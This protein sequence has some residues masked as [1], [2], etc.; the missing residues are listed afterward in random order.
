MLNNLMVPSVFVG[1]IKQIVDLF[2]NLICV[3]MEKEARASVDHH[4]LFACQLAP[5]PPSL[6]LIQTQ[7]D[8]TSLAV[9]KEANRWSQIPIYDFSSEEAELKWSLINNWGNWP[10]HSTSTSSKPISNIYASDSF[11]EKPENWPIEL[12][13]AEE[14][15][16]VNRS[17]LTTITAHYISSESNGNQSILTKIPKEMKFWRSTALFPLFSSETTPTD[18]SATTAK[19]L[20]V[21]PSKSRRV[22]AT[23]KR[24]NSLESVQVFATQSPTEESMTTDTA[25]YMEIRNTDEI[26]FGNVINHPVQIGENI[27]LVI[28]RKSRNS[29]DDGY[30]LFVHSCYASDKQGSEKVML[31]DRYGCAVQPKL[32]GQMIRME[33]AGQTYYYFRVSAF[34]F[35]GLDDVYFTCAVD[36]SQNEISPV[37]FKF[38]KIRNKR[39][40][41]FKC[42]MKGVKQR[43]TNRVGGGFNGDISRIELCSNMR[44]SNR[45]IK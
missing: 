37:L 18:I 11:E 27:L 7:D 22:N 26:P 29:K 36:I 43:R 4:F 32:T 25:V 41:K 42:C 20:K 35:P 6:P 21:K 12:F 44:V 17:L 24:T 3:Q 39:I 5:L 45:E 16:A 10:I 30:N 15:L 19:D 23:A 34:K 1:L 2:E 38:R 9:T 13:S 28:R 8:K 14:S 31:I 33:N 40:S